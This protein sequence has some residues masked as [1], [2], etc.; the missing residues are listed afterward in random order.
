MLEIELVAQRRETGCI[1]LESLVFTQISAV[2][3]TKEDRSWNTH[4]TNSMHL[5]HGRFNQ[6]IQTEA[7]ACGGPLV[8]GHTGSVRGIPPVITL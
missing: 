7:N 6:I 1:C 4:K 2:V 5:L 3:F 8:G